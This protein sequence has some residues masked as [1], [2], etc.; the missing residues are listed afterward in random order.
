[1]SFNRFEE[2]VDYVEREHQTEEGREFEAS[3]R[4]SL[5]GLGFETRLV[6][7]GELN[8]EIV[9]NYEIEATDGTYGLEIRRESGQ[10]EVYDRN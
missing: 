2:A 3:V 6:A 7:D 10:L 5:S 9:N 1:M 8:D 4:E